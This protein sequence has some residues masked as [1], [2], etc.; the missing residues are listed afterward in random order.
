MADFKISNTRPPAGDIKVGSSDV[1]KI[2]NGYSEIWPP[3]QQGEVLI[4]GLIWQTVNTNTLQKS[5]SG[6]I[7]I[8]TTPQEAYDYLVNETPAAVHFNFD[9]T[10]VR[11]VYNIWAAKLITPPE[12]FRLPTRNEWLGLKDSSRVDG[13]SQNITKIGGGVPNFWDPDV[14]ANTSYNELGFNANGVSNA[15]PSIGGGTITFNTDSWQ[16]W[17]DSDALISLDPNAFLIKENGSQIIWDNSYLANPEDKYLGIRFCKSAPAADP[18]TPVIGSSFRI[19]GY[20]SSSPFIGLFD[21]DLALVSPQPSFGALPS[22]DYTVA[23]ASDNYTYILATGRLSASLSPRI[24]TDAGATWS[25]LPA[26]VSGTYRDSD[27]AMSKSGQVM[28]LEPE[29]TYNNTVF[30]SNDYGS[31]FTQLTLPVPAE[32]NIASKQATSV[33]SGGK[34]IMISTRLVNIDTGGPAAF[35]TGL[36]V[37]QDYGVT[38]T[39]ITDSLPSPVSPVGYSQVVV[40]GEGQYQYLLSEFTNESKYSSD[41][42][43]TWVNKNYGSS[44]FRQLSAASSASGQYILFPRNTTN[45]LFTDDFGATENEVINIGDQIRASI[46]NSGEFAIFTTIGTTDYTSINYLSSFQAKPNSGFDGV[47]VDV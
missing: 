47:I 33:S 38:F 30:V 11:L 27:V 5:T 46:S 17:W 7:L 28:I 25:S 34:Y 45:G 44:S 24:S 1:Y 3:T 16:S 41:Y 43:V 12:G 26:P 31:S 39:D 40:S 20:L 18:Y 13:S 32:F 19:L 4:N 37:S 14:H 6:D 10:D 9:P 23:A 42:G 2:Y 8:A 29:E 15:T 35:K 21:S 36:F 22:S